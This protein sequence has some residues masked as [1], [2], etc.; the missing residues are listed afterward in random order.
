VSANTPLDETTDNKN[1][2]RDRNKKWNERRRR[3]QEALPIRNLDEALDQVANQVHTTPEQCLMSITTIARQAQAI[4][5]GDSH[6]QGETHLKPAKN[7]KHKSTLT[8]KTH[9]QHNHDP[10]GPR[11]PPVQHSGRPS[12]EVHLARG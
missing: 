3:F 1:A 2:R 11:G 9:T 4:R 8:P 7:A 12:S 10:G 5:V 6:N